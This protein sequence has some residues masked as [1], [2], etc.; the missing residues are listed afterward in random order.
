[1]QKKL[2]WKRYDGPKAV[3]FIIS[4]FKHSQPLLYHFALKYFDFGYQTE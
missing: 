2:L 1:M 4:F 3:E